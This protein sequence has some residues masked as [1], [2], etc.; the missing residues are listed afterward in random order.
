MRRGLLQVVAVGAFYFV[1]SALVPAAAE[2]GFPLREKFPKVKIISIEALNR[3]YQK[4]IIVDV[5]S[6]MEFD[7]IHINKAAHVPVATALFL[8]D[9]EK[10]REKTG[11]TPI[12]FYCNGHTC[13][14]SYEAVEQG[15]DAGFQNDYAYDAGIYD[16]V[17]AHPEKTTL[18]GKTPAP[19]GK[20][21]SRE[22]LA[23]RT[24]KFEEFK[25]RT[26]G[27]DA[28][29]I[30]V[31]EPFQRKEVPQLP[32]LRNIPSDRLVELLAKG[33]FKGKELLVLDAVGK[34]V[35]WIQYYLEQYGYKDYFF[36]EKGV[37]GARGAVAVK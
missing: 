17:K 13:A 2:E 31:R 15:L 3:D 1:L 37:E 11:A 27:P 7:V 32:M 18:M 29:V 5:R 36:L 9:L 22:M 28:V 16:W 33:E 20:L 19:P 12:V 30:D 8:K 24:I 25:K 34:Q 4:V 21:I 6:K 14:K 23:K 26:S 35:E 10:I